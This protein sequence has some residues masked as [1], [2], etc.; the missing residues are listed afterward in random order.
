VRT[1]VFG[2]GI[3]SMVVVLGILSLGLRVFAGR[4]FTLVPWPVA[5][6][7][8]LLGLFV[9]RQTYEHPRNRNE[10]RLREEFGESKEPKTP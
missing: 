6:I 4:E 10:R 1:L 8:L 5:L 3:A 7:V 9:L 2:R